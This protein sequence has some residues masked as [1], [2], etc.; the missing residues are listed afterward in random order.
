MLKITP[1][2]LRFNPLDDPADFDLLDLPAK[3]TGEHCALRLCE[4]F[5]TLRQIPMKGAPAQRRGGI[6][7]IC[8]DA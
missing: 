8:C 7:R 3:W 6:G 4:G 2:A 5:K 1:T